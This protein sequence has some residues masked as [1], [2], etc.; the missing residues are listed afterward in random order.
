VLKSC[1]WAR[2]TPSRRSSTS[3]P[4]WPASGSPAAPA[5][6]DGSPGS[7]A[8]APVARVELRFANGLTLED[9]ATAGV[10]LFITDQ[11]VEMPA[12]VALL[13][14]AGNELASHPAFP[15]I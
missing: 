4:A 1:A 14:E 15:G 9:D 13:D 3:S 11:N 8:A 12:T 7:C 5:P 6:A 10:A 2:Q